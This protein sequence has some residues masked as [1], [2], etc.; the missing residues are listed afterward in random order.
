M[1]S[2]SMVQMVTRLQGQNT[3]VSVPRLSTYSRLP[4]PRATA[5]GWKNPFPPR[6]SCRPIVWLYWNVNGSICVTM[7]AS[8]DEVKL[9]EGAPQNGLGVQAHPLLQQ[10]RVGAAEVVVPLQV[11]FVQ[12]LWR[13]GRILAV[14]TTFHRIAD[15]KG[16]ATRAVVRSGAVLLHAAAELG[17]HEDHHLLVGLMLLQIVVEGADSAGYIIPQFGEGDILVSVGIEGA[18]VHTGVQNPGAEVRQMHLRDVLQPLRK[19]VA[20]VLD[21]GGVHL[22]RRGEDVSP[23]Q[24]IQTGLGQIIIHRAGPNDG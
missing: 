11:A 20:V 17:E 12:L 9:L 23:F 13:Q 24:G 8:L 21:G 22:R 15:H 10:R 7:F 18:R 3:G 14:Q 4:S 5:T 2:S 1:Y 6:V 19:E 16:H